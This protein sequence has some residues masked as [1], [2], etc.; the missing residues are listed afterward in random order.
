MI[1]N[2]L[3]FLVFFIIVTTLYF[4]LPGKYQWK[5][6]LTASCYFYMVFLPVYL[7]I[8]FAIILIDFTAGI[9]IERSSKKRRK[10]Y[11]VLGLIANIGILAFFKYFNFLNDNLSLILNQAGYSNSIPN[12]SILLPI[13]L[14]FQTF[15]AMSY[16]IEVYRGKQQAE[17]HLGK[18]ALYTMFYPQLVAGPIERPQDLLK[19]FSQH[20]KFD[21]G[22]V[23]SGLK[24]MAW[25]FFKKVVIADRTALAVNTIYNHP[26]NFYGL[27]LLVGV[28]LF[29]IQIYCDFSGYTDIAAGSARVMGIKLMKNF[30][31]PNLSKSISDFWKRWHISLS[32]WF[33]DY[34]YIPLG[35]NRVKESR[36]YL[37]I[38]IVFVVSGLW[39]GA[40]WTFIIWG[41]VNG[42]YLVFESIIK[43]YTRYSQFLETFPTALVNV[44]SIFIT[45][46]LINLSRIF[47]RSNNVTDAWYILTHLF[48]RFRESIPIAMSSKIG[49]DKFDTFVILYS[50]SI[51]YLVEI[52]QSKNSIPHFISNRS[53]W[54]RH[55]IYFIVIMSI[56]LTG[57]FDSKQQFIYFQF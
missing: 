55:T 23:T 8:V 44:C 14:S 52:Y 30:N 27:P 40:N 43:K 51:L 48:T 26:Q 46:S 17:R 13:G 31:R 54:V 1:F 10:T 12:L 11:L 19:Q 42:L 3:H 2:S 57:S 53:T 49:I 24:L 15:Q 18:Y 16:I 25:G 9:W 22:D 35:G 5:I 4:G 32:S 20:H 34:L 21:Y 37:N 38:M 39:H 36:F 45:F 6:L 56:I 7:L 50:V 29:S 28:F 47:F 33:R 41:F